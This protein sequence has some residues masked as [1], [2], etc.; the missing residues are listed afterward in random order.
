MI[1]HAAAFVVFGLATIFSG[2]IGN[3]IGNMEMGGAK[4][5]VQILAAVGFVL[6]AAALLVVFYTSE[7]HPRYE[8]FPDETRREI[9]R[10][11][12]GLLPPGVSQEAISFSDIRAIEGKMFFSGWWGDRY[13]LR[14]VT[15]DWRRINI[16]QGV[17]GQP[18]EDI[19]PLAQDFAD[20]S[21]AELDLSIKLPVLR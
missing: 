11:D 2:E 15:Q 5:R 1:F 21:G 12:T 20:R 13:F 14:V 9:V 16:A 6:P 3:R 19:Y 10:R 4:I 8:V 17:R 18:P 7:D